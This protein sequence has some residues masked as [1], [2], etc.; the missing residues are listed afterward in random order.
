MSACSEAGCCT[1]VQS[2]GQTKCLELCVSG[3]A[4]TMRGRDQGGAAV[5][6]THVP[7][8]SS[9]LAAASSPPSTPM[10]LQLPSAADHLAG[11]PRTPETV[12]KSFLTLRQQRDENELLVARVEEISSRL[13]TVFFLLSLRLS[14]FSPTLAGSLF[15]I[16]L[17]SRLRSC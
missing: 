17:L 4:P 7:N 6:G 8:L 14:C 11:T 9:L 10:Q 1:C 2:C 5:G 15:H 3:P 12:A 16:F 13:Q